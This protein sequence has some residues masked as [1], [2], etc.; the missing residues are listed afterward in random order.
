MLQAI[1]KES[2]AESGVVFFKTALILVL[3]ERLS[4][5]F[6]NFLLQYKEDKRI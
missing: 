6:V 5:S 2:F 4:A 3:M 1:S